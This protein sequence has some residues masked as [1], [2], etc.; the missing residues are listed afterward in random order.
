[1]VE[2]F[3]NRQAF[4]SSL[5]KGP[6]TPVTGT[7]GKGV[8]QRPRCGF[9]IGTL[10]RGYVCLLLLTGDGNNLH[11]EPCKLA[12]GK[13]PVEEPAPAVTLTGLMP[14]EEKWKAIN[15]HRVTQPKE[16]S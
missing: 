10:R 5:T 11:Y 3:F 13:C 15:Q 6:K 2:A 14:I 4:D 1:M 7:D 8:E 16:T 12:Q 9:E